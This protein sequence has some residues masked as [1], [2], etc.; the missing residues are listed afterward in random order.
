MRTKH[1]LLTAAAGLLAAFSFRPHLW[2]LALLAISLFIASLRQDSR[3]WRVISAMT[4]AVFMY[5]PLLSWLSVVGMNATVFLV[6]VCALPW[7][8]FVLYQPNDSFV[9]SALRASGVVVLIEWVHSSVPWGGFPWGLFAYSQ[10]DGPLMWA[11]RLGGQVATTAMVVACGFALYA[12]VVHRAFALLTLTAI[13]VLVGN[14]TLH[15]TSTTDTI[16][17]AVIQ[18]NVPRLGLNPV[19][20][21]D[22]VF[23]NHIA[24]T[25]KLAVDIKNGKASPVDFVV[26]PED[27]ADGDPIAHR[28]MF[29]EI[30]QVVDELNVPILIGAAVSD[31]DL[32][33]YNSGI[34]WLPHEGPSQRYEK[35][36][37]VPFGEYIPN[38]NI[39]L[40][41][42]D[43]F[44]ITPNHYIAGKR[45]GIMTLNTSTVFG[46][47]ICF[48]IAYDNHLR[49]LIDHGASFITVQS[50][51]ATYAHTDQPMQQLQ[52]TRFRAIEHQ[53]DFAVATTTGFSAMVRAD[54]NVVAQS[55]EMSATY[56]IATLS[57]RNDR[58]PIDR[59][60]SAPWLALFGLIVGSSFIRQRGWRGT[61]FTSTTAIT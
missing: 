31:A 2:F 50:N 36:H 54:G 32:G 19:A 53:R 46:D 1:L 9:I 60:G 4:F 55:K 13:V 6:V 41:F 56:L 22:R 7:L 52:I 12:A 35:S 58:Q 17:V 14:L 42:A 29:D 59:W 24:Q 25:H 47:V 57:K 48:E 20:Q 39:L 3:K 44:G 34:L 18:G 5:G 30:Q 40:R 37:L 45:T 38:Q 27:A 33:P 49:Q 8:L 26:W 43:R 10:V 15:S 11:A 51:N 28:A 23:A 61:S 16:R 21:A